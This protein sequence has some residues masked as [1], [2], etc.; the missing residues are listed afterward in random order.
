M[1]KM[2]MP[3]ATS[4]SIVDLGAV[5]AWGQIRG[6]EDDTRNWPCVVLPFRPGQVAIAKLS[7]GFVDTKPLEFA[8]ALLLLRRS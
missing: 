6:G 3:S 1:R 7:A 8:D 5:L 2:F 4:V